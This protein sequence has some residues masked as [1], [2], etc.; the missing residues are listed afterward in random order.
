MQKEKREKLLLLILLPIFAIGLIYNFVIKGKG[1]QPESA[2]PQEV[3]ESREVKAMDTAGISLR[4]VEYTA[5]KHA[6][7]LKNQLKVYI[8]SIAPRVRDVGQRIIETVIDPP[9][10][11]ISGLI[12]NSDRPQAI[13]NGRVVS[14]GDEIDGARLLSVN[15]EGITI[16]YKGIEFPVKKFTQITSGQ[17]QYQKTERYID[18]RRRARR[19]K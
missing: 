15:K 3:Q 13:I 11:S 19:I 18:A 8:A 6:D 12:W 17:K 5:Y 1:K 7:P 16:E 9:E 14:V 4:K 2:K 10:L